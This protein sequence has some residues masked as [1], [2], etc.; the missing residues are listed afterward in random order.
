MINNSIKFDKLFSKKLNN[1]RW[2]VYVYYPDYTALYKT[3][4]IITVS[5]SD[6]H[7]H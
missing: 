5:Q 3:I 4:W 1:Y 7:N 6:I 2:I